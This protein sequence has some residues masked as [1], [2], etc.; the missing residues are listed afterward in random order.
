MIPNTLHKK[1]RLGFR[2]KRTSKL[3]SRNQSPPTLFLCRSRL[4]HKIQMGLP[5]LLM[6]FCFSA[7]W[8]KDLIVSNCFLFSCLFINSF[9]SKSSRY[10]SKIPEKEH[11]TQKT[12]LTCLGQVCL[13]RFSTILILS[14]FRKQCCMVS[15]DVLVAQRP[16]DQSSYRKPCLNMKT[17][18]K[19]VTFKLAKQRKISV[20]HHPRTLIFF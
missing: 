9:V 19:K 15:H 17:K 8:R 20:K 6:F 5:R 7:L 3:G 11:F 4:T 16:F 10:E 14:D 2:V 12:D 18:G 1:G 13:R